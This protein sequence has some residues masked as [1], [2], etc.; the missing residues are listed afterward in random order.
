MFLSFHFGKS[1]NKVLNWKPFLLKH[2]ARPTLDEFQLE[3]LTPEP[4]LM[5]VNSRRV[6][7]S[8]AHCLIF[9]AFCSVQSCGDS[10]QAVLRN[11]TT[12]LEVV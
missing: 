6:R 8:A 10:E 5:A 9:V 7:S 2:T 3:T 12:V 11:T 4:M 1:C